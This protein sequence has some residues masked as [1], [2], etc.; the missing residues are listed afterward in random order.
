MASVV[1]VSK[2]FLEHVLDVRYM[3]AS[4]TRVESRHDSRLTGSTT[5]CQETERGVTIVSPKPYNR[6]FVCT[7]RDETAKRGGL[8]SRHVCVRGT[9]SDFFLQPTIYIHTT[10]MY[11][12]C[13]YVVA[14]GT[15]SFSSSLFWMQRRMPACV[16]RIRNDFQSRSKRLKEENEARKWRRGADD[17][18]RNIRLSELLHP[19]ATTATTTTTT[20]A[21]IRTR[22]HKVA[23]ASR[24]MGRSD[25]AHRP[26]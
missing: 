2:T 23:L 18:G 24:N 9:D 14:S 10:C 11:I 6:S 1:H 12:E 20:A 16:L 19:V 8:Q 4:Q 3:C 22:R 15:Q 5:Y 7:D 25:D 21:T 13:T 17:E 26:E